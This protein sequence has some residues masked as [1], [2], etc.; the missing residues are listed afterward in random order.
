MTA[1]APDSQQSTAL[2][3]QSRGNRISRSSAAASDRGNDAIISDLVYLPQPDEE[4]GSSNSNDENFFAEFRSEMQPHANAEIKA[5]T[6]FNSCVWALAALGGVF[7]LAALYAAKNSASRIA[8]VL[9]ISDFL[10]IITSI[11]GHMSQRIE[12][13]MMFA[14]FAAMVVIGALHHLTVIALL[15]LDEE[16]FSKVFGGGTGQAAYE[17]SLPVLRYGSLLLSAI[18]VVCLVLI[19]KLYNQDEHEGAPYQALNP[20][21]SAREI[22]E[23]PVVGPTHK[24]YRLAVVSHLLLDDTVRITASSDLGCGPVDEYQLC[25]RA[26]GAA[27]CACVLREGASGAYG[28]HIIQEAREYSNQNLTKD[29][30]DPLNFMA[31]WVDFSHQEANQ[32]TVG[33]LSN[34]IMEAKSD[35]VGYAMDAKAICI[36]FCDANPRQSTTLVSNV[37][38]ACRFIYR[39]LHCPEVW[40][41]DASRFE[42]GAREALLTQLT[43]PDKVRAKDAELAA[44]GEWGRQAYREKFARSVSENRRKTLM[45][46]LNDYLAYDEYKSLEDW[47]RKAAKSLRAK[48]MRSQFNR[49]LNMR[50]HLD[51]DSVAM[52]LTP[53][54]LIFLLIALVLSVVLLA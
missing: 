7:C 10:P 16:A 15:S 14:I 13:E 23:S 24:P 9:L 29:G 25:V 26:T 42:R 6:V 8:W 1:Q 38:E 39:A 20:E 21:A 52:H 43:M 5:S 27:L 44:I 28:R 35:R 30:I 47:E 40:C 3:T 41:T 33:G 22:L 4:Q 17:R 49:A 54:C 19:Y 31:V 36:V 46:A 11:C 48:R 53:E 2:L 37:K 45:R 18:E 34:T 51:N 50:Y 32:E 12:G